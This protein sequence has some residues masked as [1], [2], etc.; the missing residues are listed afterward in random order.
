MGLS[1][2]SEVKKNVTSAQK[3]VGLMGKELD[4]KKEMRPP[5]VE[6]KL[7]RP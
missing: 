1:R 4:R 7:P 3:E 5:S 6:C 2:N